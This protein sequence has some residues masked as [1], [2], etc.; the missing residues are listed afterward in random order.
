[1]INDVPGYVYYIHDGYKVKI[2]YTGFSPQFRIPDLQTGNPNKL[3]LIKVLP[4]KNAFLAS[5]AEKILHKKYDDIRVKTHYSEWFEYSDDF[6]DEDSTSI[7]K[8]SLGKS[9]E[10]IHTIYG[11]DHEIFTMEERPTCFFYPEASAQIINSKI[12]SQR[13]SNPYRTMAYPTNGKQLLLPFS[14]D[15]D[16]VF[17]SHRKHKQNMELAKF[18][19]EKTQSNS[20]GQ[21]ILEEESDLM[22]FLL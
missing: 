9:K 7:F 19:K 22:E 15:Y 6:M 5:E 18:I 17:I 14:T 4:F 20:L 8:S 11:D 3:E 10:F 1:M 2:G 13:N 21:Y 12:K 16:R